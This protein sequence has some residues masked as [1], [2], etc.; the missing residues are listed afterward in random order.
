MFINYLS[1]D[2][3]SQTWGCS[4]FI[5]VACFLTSNV[6]TM[7]PSAKSIII[8]HICYQYLQVIML[9]IIHCQLYINYH[10][11]DFVIWSLWLCTDTHHWLDAFLQ[12]ISDKCAQYTRAHNCL[13]DLN[14]TL[15]LILMYVHHQ[16]AKKYN[17]NQC[18]LREC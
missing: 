9:L 5:L 13:T 8:S 18:A 12:Q 16:P 10:Y 2:Y 17:Y 4:H 3:N 6:I 14:L 1:F 7:A 11:E 15:W